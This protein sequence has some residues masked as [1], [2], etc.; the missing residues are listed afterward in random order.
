MNSMEFA[1]NAEHD[2]E[3][4]YTEQ[5]EINRDNDLNT[6]FILLAK[7]E[8]NHAR[9]LQNKFNDLSYVLQD[10]NTLSKSKNVFKGSGDFK[11]EIRTIPNQL[12]LYRFALEK[13]KQSIDLYKKLL[14]E[15]TDD[16]TKK[17]FEYLIK[18][19]VEHFAILEELV[20][21]VSRPDEWVESA[22]FGEHEF[23]R[24]EKY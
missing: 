23:G 17:L 5:A 9:I 7:D 4:Y 13:E 15:S 22:E 1:I 18:Q 2:G 20:L 24:K 12:D 3:K 11:N 16:R 14:S 6:V 21:L 8:E 10:N 19:E